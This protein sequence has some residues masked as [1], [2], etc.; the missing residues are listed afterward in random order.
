M[1]YHHIP[2]MFVGNLQVTSV[3]QQFLLENTKPAHYTNTNVLR[4]NFTLFT[5]VMAIICPNISF[6]HHSGR[7][8]PSSRS[9]AGCYSSNL[10]FFQPFGRITL[11]S[12]PSAGCYSSNDAFPPP[13][14]TSNTPFAV[15][16]KTSSGR[17]SLFK[18]RRPDNEFH[19][20]Y[21]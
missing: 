16:T 2:T 8:T 20:L 1:S 3:Y 12:R 4:T 21:L 5:A 10:A 14:W 9:A 17:R 15:F 19:L 11:P 18:S 7:T 13:F 6:F